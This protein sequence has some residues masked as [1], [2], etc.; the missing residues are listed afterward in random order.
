MVTY[1]AKDTQQPELFKHPFGA[2]LD[3]NHRYVILAN[4]IPWDALAAY[5]KKSL[6]A[7]NGR[8]T[9]DLRI[10]LGTLVLQHLE[11]LSDRRVIAYVQESLYAQYFL[12]LPGFVTH[13]LFAPSLLVEV[14]NRLGERGAKD[15]N[16]IVS[17][18]LRDQPIDLESLNAPGPSAGSTSDTSS[19]AAPGH[20]LDTDVQEPQTPPTPEPLNDAKDAEDQEEIPSPS[21][22]SSGESTQVAPLTDQPTTPDASQDKPRN[23]GTLIVDATVAPA[24]IA[25]PTD[26]ALLNTARE[27]TERII[28]HLWRQVRPEAFAPERKPRTHRKQARRLAVNFSKTKNKDSD[29]I[30]AQIK[31]ELKYLKRNITTIRKLCVLMDAASLELTLPKQQQCTML[32][33]LA[34]Y[35]QQHKMYTHKTHTIADRIVSVEQWHIRPIKRGK[36]GGRLTEFGPKLNASLVDGYVSVDLIACAAF[37][38]ALDLRAQVE[39]YEAEYGHLPEVVLADRIYFTRA[40]RLFL[41][42]HGIVSNAV[43]L[44]PTPKLTPAERKLG[45]KRHGM[46][47]R[48]EAKFGELKVH[49]SLGRLRAKRLA[50]QLCEVSIACLA[51]NLTRWLR[52]LPWLC[53]KAAWQR[54][55]CLVATLWTVQDPQANHK[56]LQASNLRWRKIEPYP[57]W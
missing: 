35:E 23:S 45:A 17:L 33:V 53:F 57:S 1:T 34:I 55:A 32:V 6:C 51:S 40:N 46:R 28:D 5:Y 16:L 31:A 26:T 3:P 44:G 52:G 47:S 9:I 43:P 48:V 14:R 22:C 24:P 8:P 29:L 39:R 19:S 10:V 30:R 13:A 50:T 37:N 25:Y 20:H 42:Q 7:T 54:L 41:N 27:H 49:Y 11:K 18:A 15:L 12:G 2:H 38:E 56:S 4:K 36:S 21:P